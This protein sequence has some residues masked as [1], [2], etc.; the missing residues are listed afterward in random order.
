MIMKDLLI[1]NTYRLSYPES[2][3]VMDPEERSRQ[4]F[5]E[6]GPGVCLSDP[7][8][9]ILIS[10]AWKKVGKLW[11]SLLKTKDLKKAMEACTVKPMQAF[12][13][14]TEEACEVTFCGIET[15]GFGF[16]Y[17]VQDTDM[18]GRSYVM[19]DEG[20]LWYFHCYVREE[21]REEGFRLF[22]EILASAERLRK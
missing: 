7:D 5:L 21:N 12:Q 18:A 8:K 16:S 11:Y 15:G 14:R 2:F 9:H 19:K 6:T 13:I 4:N 1:N 20:T 10:I 22:A 3:F 17:Q